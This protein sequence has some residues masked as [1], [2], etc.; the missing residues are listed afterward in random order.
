MGL[1]ARA[2][3]GKDGPASA[4]QTLDWLAADVAREYEDK[5]YE[6]ISRNRTFTRSV[7]SFTPGSLE[8]Y[9]SE[10]SL[11]GKHRGFS[12]ANLSRR[13]DLV[14]GDIHMQVCL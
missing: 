8:Q 13:T 11:N 2:C 14:G 10:E 7:A 5:I 4:G 9:R 12:V 6:R 1:A 3:G